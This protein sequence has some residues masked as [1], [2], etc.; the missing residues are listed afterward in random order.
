MTI[1]ES[2]FAS[3]VCPFGLKSGR[4]SSASAKYSQRVPTAQNTPSWASPETQYTRYP[5]PP[6]TDSDSSGDSDS[7]PEITDPRLDA[8]STSKKI[9]TSGSSS[10]RGDTTRNS[11]D[12]FD[13]WS[14]P[15]DPALHD[16]LRKRRRYKQ[17]STKVE[18]KPERRFTAPGESSSETTG[19]RFDSW[20]PPDSNEA[21]IF[22]PPLS[23]DQQ[24]SGSSGHTSS[25]FERVLSWG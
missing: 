1:L 10:H 18:A 5:Q 8:K 22:F 6:D 4:Q 12:T 20:S 16:Y 7:H 23:D 25:L 21:I 9:S 2:A 3:S 19:N 15:G 17:N 24:S 14:A 13:P 11:T